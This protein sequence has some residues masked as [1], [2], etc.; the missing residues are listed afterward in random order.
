MLSFVRPRDLLI[1]M[2]YFS[3]SK[4][5]Q[6]RLPEETNIWNEGAFHISSE[7]LTFLSKKIKKSVDFNFRKSL[8]FR[9]F[10]V[11]EILTFLHQ[12]FW[13]NGKY[14]IQ[15]SWSFVPLSLSIICGFCY[16]IYIG[17]PVLFCLMG[18]RKPCAATFWAHAAFGIW[19]ELNQKI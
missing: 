8:L 7:I 18:H 4:T 13:K 3:T 16:N 12:Y 17:D 5:H 2:V 19:S 10:W 15:L 9:R 14:P 6:M 11:S 1:S